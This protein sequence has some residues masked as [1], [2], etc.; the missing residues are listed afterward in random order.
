MYQKIN[1]TKKKD[2]SNVNVFIWIF[3]YKLYFNGYFLFKL[4]HEFSLTFNPSFNLII[5]FI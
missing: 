4:I 2:L 5:H 3:F 1:I